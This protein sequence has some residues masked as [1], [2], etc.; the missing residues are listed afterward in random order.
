MFARK[1]SPERKVP[2][3]GS[4]AP[5]LL[6]CGWIMLGLFGAAYMFGYVA[7][8]IP[9][10]RETARIEASVTAESFE[11]LAGEIGRLNARIAALE[12]ALGPATSAIPEKQSGA[13]PQPSDRPVDIATLPLPKEGFG[14]EAAPFEAIPIEAAAATRTVFAVAVSVSEDKSRLRGSWR[15]LLGRYGEILEGLEPRVVAQVTKKGARRWKLVAGPF[16]NAAGA[17]R[18]C[19]RLKAARQPCAET[20]FSGDAL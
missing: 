1:T 18:A 12:T 16:E 13:E 20:V 17:A 2:R 11:R 4:A 5:A 14:D 8:P 3:R 6:A 15:D 7:D 9:P 10:K 19:A